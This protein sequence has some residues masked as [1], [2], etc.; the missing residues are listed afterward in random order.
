M[1]SHTVYYKFLTLDLQLLSIALIE[2]AGFDLECNAILGTHACS[3][4]HLHSSAR[5]WA[6]VHAA[7]SDQSWPY[8]SRRVASSISSEEPEHSVDSTL[9]DSKHDKACLLL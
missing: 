5:A 6:A 7:H 3:R 9:Q 1:P 8:T 4:F 2:H